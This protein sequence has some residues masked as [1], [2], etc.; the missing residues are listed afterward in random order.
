MTSEIGRLGGAH[1]DEAGPS[2]F[3]RLFSELDSS[4]NVASISRSIS[5]TVEAGCGISISGGPEVEMTSE[6][7]GLG[8]AHLDEASL[9]VLPDIFVI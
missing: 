9:L 6:T 1:L 7:S 3:T 8:V 4:L 5:I 2:V